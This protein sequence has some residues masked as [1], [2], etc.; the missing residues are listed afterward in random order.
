MDTGRTWKLETCG[1]Q[2]LTTDFSVKIIKYW[3]VTIREEE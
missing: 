1:A 2:T 3:H